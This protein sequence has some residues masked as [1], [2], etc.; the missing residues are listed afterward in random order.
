MSVSCAWI[1]RGRLFVKRSDQDVIEIESDFA[2]NSLERDMRRAGNN[3]WKG[4]SGV[5]GSL[6][7]EP[8][9][10]AP[11]ENVEAL[12]QIRFVCV[13]PGDHP[14]EI[15]YVL[16]LGA[17]GGLFRYDM[18]L[19]EETR[20]MHSQAF[21]ARDLSRHPVDRRIAVSVVRD[22]GTMGLSITRP[23]GLFGKGVSLS[24][25]IDEAPA[26]VPDGSEKLVFQSAAIGRNEAGAAVGQTTRRIE[27][28]DLEAEQITNLLEQ[29]EFDLLQPR[30]LADGSLLYLRRPYRSSHRKPPTFL[31]TLQDVIYFPFRLARTVVYFFNFMSMAFSGKP[32][33]TAGRQ[34]QN[35]DQD[36]WLVLYGHTIDT[37]K[38]MAGGADKDSDRPLVPKDWELVRHTDGSDSVLATGVASFDAD[39]D[40]RIVYSNGR[41]VY[42]LTEDGQATK[43]GDGDLVEK[44]VLLN[45]STFPP[46]ED[47]NTDD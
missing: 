28:L 5:W 39:P 14:D 1:S 23:D 10:D 33:M 19:E 42:L 34:P 45:R 9:G 24:D 20:L 18:E 27:L 37:R 13:T 46:A 7:M 2:R 26:W 16:D 12:R 15:Y 31:E 29:D 25:T 41:S 35:K 3:A 4:R 36:P 32:L 8:P 38:A 47:S 22:D 44:V 40:G 17:V 30:M 43:L 6:G 21:Q 11:W